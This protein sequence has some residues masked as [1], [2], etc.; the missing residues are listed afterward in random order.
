MRRVTPSIPAAPALVP[1][2]GV[3]DPAL[4]L[5]VGL[6]RGNRTGLFTRRV[7]EEA[8]RRLG[9]KSKLPFDSFGSLFRRLHPGPST[10]TLRVVLTGKHRIRIPYDILGYHPG[11]LR[12]SPSLELEEWDLGTLRLDPRSRRRAGAG[13]E[14]ILE[15]R[16]VKLWGVRRGRLDMDID[17]WLDAMMGSR[18][19]D[20]RI[21]GIALYELHGHT[22]GMALGY[23]RG[24][25]GRSGAFDL[26]ADRILFPYPREYKA[27]GAFLR[28][29]LEQLMPETRRRRS[30]TQ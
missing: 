27:A 1:A 28:G 3:A 20:T 19:D 8:V 22:I 11:K 14:G 30:R 2:P 23:S 16:R 29:R 26:T 6:I 4:A 5:M 13:G 15:L 17:G 12:A 25:E 9:R 7:F 10:A 18:L 21:T 24:G